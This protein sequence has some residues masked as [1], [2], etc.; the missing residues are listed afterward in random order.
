MSRSVIA[1][2]LLGLVVGFAEP[3]ATQPLATCRGGAFEGPTKPTRPPVVGDVRN[4]RA[5]PTASRNAPGH[6]PMPRQGTSQAARR[7]ALETAP[8]LQLASLADASNTAR[9][10]RAPSVLAPRSLL[11]ATGAASYS[12]YHFAGNNTIDAAYTGLVGFLQ[13]RDPDLSSTGGGHVIGNFLWTPDYSYYYQTGWID[14]AY[15]TNYPRVFVETNLPG[16][17]CR[18]YFDQFPLADGGQYY[19]ATVSKP[20]GKYGLIWWNSTWHELHPVS[21]TIQR[22]GVMQ[23]FLEVLTY[24]DHPTVNTTSNYGSTLV[25]QDNLYTWDTS[26][27]TSTIANAPYQ[28]NFVAAYHDWQAG[29]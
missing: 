24:A 3:R 10:F 1:V 8:R 17:C 16:G 26:I 29:S 12:G 22:E 13:V 18:Y 20:A 5:L 2:I 6:G 15:G 9:P 21:S 19:F 4:C 14:E 7:R 28:L 25:Y 23:Q 11:S 27:A